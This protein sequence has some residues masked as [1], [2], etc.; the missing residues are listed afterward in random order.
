MPNLNM[1]LNELQVE[2]SSSQGT[3]CWSEG[4]DWEENGML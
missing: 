4:I 1:Q 3:Y 2:Y